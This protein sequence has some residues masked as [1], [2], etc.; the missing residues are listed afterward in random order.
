MHQNK[1]QSKFE[2]N[3]DQI[4]KPMLK[5]TDESNGSFKKVKI[6]DDLDV[7]KKLAENSVSDF[8][9]LFCNQD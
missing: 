4:T 5:L 1:D 2:I 9:H 6:F 8:L 3:K 7:V